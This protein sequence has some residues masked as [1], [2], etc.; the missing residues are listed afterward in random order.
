[1]SWLDAFF[2][3]YIIRSDGTD[4]TS[5]EALNFIGFSFADDSVNNEIEIN[6]PTGVTNQILQNNGSSYTATSNLTLPSGA[7]RT[8]TIA[9]PTTATAGDSLTIYPGD[10]TDAG[11]LDSG[12]NLVLRCGEGAPG[13][14]N[15]ELQLLDGE[16]AE[17]ITIANI[18]IVGSASA[19]SF[20][21]G[22]PVIQQGPIAD[23]TDS[24]GGSAGNTIG[25]VS[26][27]GDDAQINDNFASLTAKVQ[28]LKDALENYRLL[29]EYLPP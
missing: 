16:A 2:S 22:N 17:V 18:G 26:G 24:S 19:L 15:G 21:G 8:I 14:D 23:T 13:E 28:A 1:M 5:R 10:G 29:V 9:D 11:A 3:A 27:S 25:A 4:Q 7:N 12:G 20:F 6:L